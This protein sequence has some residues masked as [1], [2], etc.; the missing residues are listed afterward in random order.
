RAGTAP[1]RSARQLPGARGAWRRRRRIVIA[2]AGLIAAAIVAAIVTLVVVA[3]GGNS[4]PS[5]PPASAAPAARITRIALGEGAA[6]SSVVA[7]HDNAYVLNVFGR[8]VAVVDGLSRRTLG[9][10]DLPG[11]PRSLVLDPGRRRLWVGLRDR[12]VVGVGLRDHGLRGEPLQL[13]VTPDDLVMLGR[14][15]VA[16]QHNPARLVRVDADRRRIVGRPVTPGGA[17]TGAIAYGGSL[18]ATIVYPPSLVRFDARLRRTGS[19]RLDASLPSDLAVD[20]KGILWMPDFDAGKVLR[21]DPQTGVSREPPIPVGRN[22][23][24]VALDGTSAWVTNKGDNTVT[25]IRESSGRPFTPAI[26]TGPLAGAIAPRDDLTG[27]AWASGTNEL[28]DLE[29]PS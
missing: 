17:A 19:H 18:L 28:L 8:S 20:A 13:P 3:P 21:V 26:P 7:D 12:R 15:L 16:V 2:L 5:R 27:G 9:Q 29:P 14:Q 23:T 22:P 25:R 1:V 4:P 11:R 10:V 6:A 24:A